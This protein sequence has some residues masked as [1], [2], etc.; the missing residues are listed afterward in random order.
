MADARELALSYLTSHHVMTLATRA[1]DDLWA[2]A[3][4]YVNLEFELYFLSA[5]HTRHAR[6][7]AQQ[8]RVAATIQENVADWSAIKGIQLEGAVAQLEGVARAEAMAR[9]LGRFP[10]LSSAPQAIQYALERVNWY[11]LQPDRL[12]F[13]DNSLGFGHR[14][15]VI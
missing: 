10:F 13:I 12:Y 7:I 5:A 14:D 3:V 1:E 8:P 2:A 9:Y 4:F 15:Q 6:H 11:R